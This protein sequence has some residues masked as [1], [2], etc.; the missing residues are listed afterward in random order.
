MGRGYARPAK[1]S[2]LGRDG[3]R[4]TFGEFQLRGMLACVR[5]SE[6][7]LLAKE[8]R[9]IFCIRYARPAKLSALASDD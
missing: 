6:Q 7:C 3:P 1:L 2:T 4:R 5:L 8:L 9:W